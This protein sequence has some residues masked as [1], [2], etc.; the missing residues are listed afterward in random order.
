MTAV[1]VDAR[2]RSGPSRRLTRRG[3]FV[4][5]AGLVALAFVVLTLFGARSAAVPAGTPLEPT[6]TVT[7]QPGET[8]WNIA[9]RVAPATDPRET[10]E[11][12]VRLNGLDSAGD[13]QIGQSIAVPVEG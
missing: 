10:I 4:A 2:A 7:V 11:Q 5:V 8:M 1:V 6:R 3:Q 9:A 12:I 13:L